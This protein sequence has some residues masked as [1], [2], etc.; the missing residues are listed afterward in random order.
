MQPS[1][2]RNL[3]V[4][5][6]IS[7]SIWTFSVCLSI[8]SLALNLSLLH[9][10]FASLTFSLLF[11]PS[12]VEAYCMS[13]I[14]YSVSLPRSQSPVISLN[15]RFTSLSLSPLSSDLTRY[16]CYMCLPTSFLSYFTLS[17]FALHQPLVLSHVLPSYVHYSTT[18]HYKT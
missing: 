14:R 16:M 13:L 5:N 12:L 9:S 7:P 4:I 8:V 17:I 3:M 18:T 2:P 11:P 10:P 15:P 1:S 6:T